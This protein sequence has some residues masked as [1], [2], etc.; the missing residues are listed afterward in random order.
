M[1]EEVKENNKIDKHRHNKRFIQAVL[2]K[3]IPEKLNGL[4]YVVKNGQHLGL[5][6]FLIT[7]L[8]QFMHQLIS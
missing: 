5:L 2:H 3:Y 4:M 8:I 7:T 1:A 6:I